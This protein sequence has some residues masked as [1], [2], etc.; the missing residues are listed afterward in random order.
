MRRDPAA[1]QRKS[2]PDENYQFSR[3][4][5]RPPP[6]RISPAPLAGGNRA[7]SFAS[8]GDTE[9]N[10]AGAQQQAREAAEALFMPRRAA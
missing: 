2:W 3:F 7:I 1:C 9:I 4:A 6:K 5:E 8:T 10:S